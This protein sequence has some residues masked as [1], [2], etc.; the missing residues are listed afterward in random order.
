MTQFNKQQK[1]ENIYDKEVT[2]KDIW[3]NYDKIV[4][5]EEL[6]V[7]LA[8][9][10]KEV[11]DLLNRGLYRDK[12]RAEM[13]ERQRKW[14]QSEKGKANHKLWQERHRKQRKKYVDNYRKKNK[15]KIRQ[16]AREYQK[17]NKDKINLA[18]RLRYANEK[19]NAKRKNEN[20]RTVD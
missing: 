17:L 19:L 9:I 3:D 10:K 14:N 11:I 7:P 4:N 8:Q 16:K 1:R 6:T 12:L 2:P 5:G 13:R 15:K 20:K 18:Q